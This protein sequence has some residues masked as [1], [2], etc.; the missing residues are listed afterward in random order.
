M[1]VFLIRWGN[2]W[3]SVTVASLLQLSAKLWD[4]VTTLTPP[5]HQQHLTQLCSIQSLKQSSIIYMC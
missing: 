5:A 2:G 3:R 1:T 4:L